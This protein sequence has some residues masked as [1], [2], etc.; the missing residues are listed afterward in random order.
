M[1]SICL[2]KKEE[3]EKEKWA[4]YLY[5]SQMM[6]AGSWIDLISSIYVSGRA[7][8]PEAVS[9][10]KGHGKEEIFTGISQPK[11]IGH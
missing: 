10:V 4:A 3:K 2:I 1:G 11:H 6:V 8:S 5:S 7:E 9:N